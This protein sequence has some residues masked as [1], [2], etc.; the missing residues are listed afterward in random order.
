ML[1]VSSVTWGKWGLWRAGPASVS[2]FRMLAHIIRHK[3]WGKT[4]KMTNLLAWSVIFRCKSVIRE[5][6]T[7]SFDTTVIVTQKSWFF[8]FQTIPRRRTRLVSVIF[9]HCSQYKN[10]TLFLFLFLHRECRGP[11]DATT[12]QCRPVVSMCAPLFFWS[13]SPQHDDREWYV[14]LLFRW[15]IH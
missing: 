12:Q 10:T 8:E 13:L 1:V 4:W 6:D 2:A 3:G 7:T 14:F 15:N 5:D 11:W 9:G